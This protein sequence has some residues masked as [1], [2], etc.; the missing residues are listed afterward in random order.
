[1]L[2]SA[3][4]LVG[5]FESHTRPG[6][7]LTADASVALPDARVSDAG[8]DGGPVLCAGELTLELRSPDECASV[9]IRDDDGPDR[10][11][12]GSHTDVPSYLLHV[13]GEGS[14]GFQLYVA[15]QPPFR[16]PDGRVSR[17][18]VHPLPLDSCG[19]GSSGGTGGESTVGM[20]SPRPIYHTAISTFRVFVDGADRIPIMFIACGPTAPAP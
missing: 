8:W 10:C 2:L 4:F 11:V 5:C 17:F 7:A 3:G 14:A 19:C 9:I 12:W 16:D 15:G 6:E 13:V 20:T 18:T 1:M